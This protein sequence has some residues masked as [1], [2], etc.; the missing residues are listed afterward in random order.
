[1]DFLLDYVDALLGL[2]LAMVVGLFF[3]RQRIAELFQMR[4]MASS[5]YVVF[6]AYPIHLENL[7][8]DMKHG[9]WRFVSFTP[10][11]GETSH[12]RFEKSYSSRQK[13]GDLI[14]KDG[15]PLTA[16]RREGGD[17]LVK[18]ADHGKL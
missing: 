11:K 1:M 14:H 15:M 13:L 2:G 9:G 16:N 7:V 18:I 12:Y 17:L 8:A 4:A 3:I 10:A 5:T 6:D